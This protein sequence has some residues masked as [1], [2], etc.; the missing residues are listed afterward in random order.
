MYAEELAKKPVPERLKEA[1]RSLLVY[2]VASDEKMLTV[3]P[4]H[5]LL[6]DVGG[7]TKNAIRD[8]LARYFRI[9]EYPDLKK[10][11]ARLERL[12]D[13][14]VFGM[15]LGGGKFYILIIK[16]IK[17]SDRTIPGKSKDWKRLDVAILHLFIFQHVL[18]VKDSDENVEFVKSPEETAALIDKG[19]FKAA[20]FL[21]PTKVA[22][23][24]RIAKLG[25]KM[26]RK[27]TYFYPKPVS[28]VV[29]NKH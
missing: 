25:E 17:A 21:N 12:K 11:M 23:I 16:D 7:L 3:L 13:E 26:P 9:E 2:F 28:G 20:F 15:Y 29:I 22:Q 24:K 10:M 6:A 14:H 19:E 1:A 18:G 8:R 4:A 27:A 5:R